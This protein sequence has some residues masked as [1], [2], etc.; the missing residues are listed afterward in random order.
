MSSLYRSIEKSFFYTLG[1][2]LLGN[3][4]GIASMVL[5]G[6]LFLYMWAIGKLAPQ[7]LAE[8]R[9]ITGV[10][11]GL[12]MLACAGAFFYL[13]H[14]IVRPVHMLSER[15]DQLANGEGDLS[16]NLPV[17]TQD[18][19]RDLAENYNAFMVRLRDLI[20]EI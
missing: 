3:V 20:H 2:K 8:F 14:L 16:V 13:R 12:T 7:Q 11:L 19:L 15:M 5:L 1:R 6:Y 18:E 9:M 10:F 17:V 4:A